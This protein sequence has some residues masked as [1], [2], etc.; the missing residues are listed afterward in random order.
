MPRV[1]TASKDLADAQASLE[2]AKQRVSKCYNHVQDDRANLASV[3]DPRN[4]R[5]AQTIKK[6]QQGLRKWEELLAEAQTTLQERTRSVDRARER[7]ARE[8]ALR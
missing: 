7:V 1:T 2:H 6:A 4:A 3:S 5:S 8:Q